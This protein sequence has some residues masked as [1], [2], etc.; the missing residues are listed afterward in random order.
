LRESAWRAIL[1]GRE[2]P[3]VGAALILSTDPERG[4]S[5]LDGAHEGV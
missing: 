1:N 3:R 2:T 5:Y 4:P